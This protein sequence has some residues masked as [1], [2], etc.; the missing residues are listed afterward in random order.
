MLD[1]LE[2]ATI[3]P[4]VLAEP[5]FDTTAVPDRPVNPP[6]VSTAFVWATYGSV[7]QDYLDGQITNIQKYLPAIRALQ[8]E[9][10]VET[11]QIRRETH[12]Q[13]RKVLDMAGA[14]NAPG[15]DGST[16]LTL[17]TLREEELIKQSEVTAKL[18]AQRLQE[19]Y[20]I[21]ENNLALGLQSAVLRFDSHH[22]MQSASFEVAK[23]VVDTATK[24]TAQQVAAYNDSLKAVEASWEQTRV[25]LKWKEQQ[26]KLYAESVNAQKPAAE[27][28]ALV[29]EVLK[30]DAETLAVNAKIAALQYELQLLA[31]QTEYN[32][33]ML[34]VAQTELLV[35]NARAVTA[36][37]SVSLSKERMVLAGVR[38]QEIDVSVQAEQVQK[39]K[40]LANEQL[41]LT[42][43]SVQVKE[44]D[45]RNLRDRL[46]VL[47]KQQEAALTRLRIAIPH[48]E[49]ASV[50]A[51]SQ[52]LEATTSA[53]IASRTANATLH[54]NLML[55][56]HAQHLQN[57]TEIYGSVYA[58]T[59]TN[60][61][62]STE[63]KKTAIVT[64]AENAANSTVSSDFYYYRAQGGV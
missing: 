57:M 34:E 55:N 7:V 58:Q 32:A 23:A 24:L 2:I 45:L 42:E 62:N 54:H 31:K 59:L 64:A 18:T 15:L 14:R 60:L 26:V 20:A 47:R 43:I 11:L 50:D 35:A 9:L 48:S 30:L 4:P 21:Y 46:E 22:K 39:Q 8:S 5:V 28:A 16:I 3:A 10:A 52:S 29:G 6:P 1:F 17:Q 12:Q 27:Q 56:E 19:T 51:K 61:N 40:V 38:G 25:W 44:E 36:E 53:E 33:V 37:Y 63:M 49:I 41:Q 13:R